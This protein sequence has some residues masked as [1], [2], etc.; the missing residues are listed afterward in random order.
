FSSA[1]AVVR[2]QVQQV[3]L[4]ETTEGAGISINCS[5]PTI[6]LFDYIYWYRLLPGRGPSFLVSGH[7]GNKVMRNP[8]GRLLV[9][10]DRKSSSLWLQ[11]PRRSDAGIYY[12]TL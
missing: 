1:V 4:A 10:K 5:H 2:A 8:L 6:D 9:S 3:K 7:R 12:C 11:H